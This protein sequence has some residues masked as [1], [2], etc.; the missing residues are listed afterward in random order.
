MSLR[1]CSWNVQL[2]LR[3]DAILAALDEL[4]RPDVLAL[5]EASRAGGVEDAA[6]VAERLGPDYE[7]WQVTAQHLRG[8]EQANALVWNRRRIRVEGRAVIE[9]PRSRRSRRNALMVEGRFGR[10]RLRAYCVHLDVLGV[11][12]RRAQLG[13]VLEHDAGRPP[14]SLVVIAGDLNTFGLNG[15]PAWARLHAEARAHGFEDVTANVGWTQARGRLRQKLDAV[16]ARPPEL[17]SR[18]WAL[19]LPGSDHIPVLAEIA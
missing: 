10:G 5:Q 9:L 1:V 3:L 12:H 8:R 11:A 16:L 15:R 2:G 6:R 7:W 13:A 19:N 17:V 14:A 18:S 4:G